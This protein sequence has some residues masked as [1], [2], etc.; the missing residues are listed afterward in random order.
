[1]V[2]RRRCLVFR[3]VDE[4]GNRHR[5]Y[6]QREIATRA[7][8]E[9]VGFEIAAKGR[10]LRPEPA[11][12]TGLASQTRLLREGGQRFGRLCGKRCDNDRKKRRQQSVCSA[13]QLHVSPPRG[14]KGRENRPNPVRG[15]R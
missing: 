10:E 11:D 2:G 4:R 7:L 12:M 3:G 13:M 8:R 15:K 9:T 14:Q 1:M 6:R 5:R